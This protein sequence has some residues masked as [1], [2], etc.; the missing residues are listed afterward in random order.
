MDSS[1]PQRS[2]THFS[3]NLNLKFTPLLTP[4]W[5]IKVLTIFKIP[6][7]MPPSLRRFTK[8]PKPE[9]TPPHCIITFLTVSLHPS[10][11][12]DAWLPQFLAATVAKDWVSTTGEEI[13]A[14]LFP[15]HPP[16]ALLMS[17]QTAPMAVIS[18]FDAGSQDTASFS[19]LSGT[20][21]TF[22]IFVKPLRSSLTMECK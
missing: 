8:S 17:I 12:W 1:I 4:R 11:L 5:T 3:S 19:L 21:T 18:P 14:R 10:E 15:G 22:I 16:M 20:Y 9:Y 6:T 7:Q 13:L 2:P